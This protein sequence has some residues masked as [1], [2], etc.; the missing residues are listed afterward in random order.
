MSHQALLLLLLLLLLQGQGFL[1]GK[2]R[3]F[4]RQYAQ[5]YFSR[6]LKLRQIVQQQVQQAW[7]GTPGALAGQVAEVDHH[8]MPYVASSSNCPS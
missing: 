6:L 5:L 3:S 1:L 2:Q 4:D 8:L 7:P